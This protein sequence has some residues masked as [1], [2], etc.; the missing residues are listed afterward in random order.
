MDGASRWFFQRVTGIALL[1][2][3]LGHFFVTHYYPPGDI[4]FEK[5]AERLTQ[6]GWKFF[7]LAFLVLALF[8]GLN[9]GWTVLEDYLKEGWARIALFG[10]LVMAALFLF[11]LGTLTILGFQA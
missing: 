2:F 6:P 7:N 1:V 10:A 8:H 5:V 3:L 4:T 9:G 11:V